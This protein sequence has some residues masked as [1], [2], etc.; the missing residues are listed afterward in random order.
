MTEEQEIITENL[1][2]TDKVE[3]V[4]EEM[5]EE[6]LGL[7]N[8]HRASIG[9]SALL[10]SSEVYPFAEDH[11]SYM[12]SQNQLSH[13][14]FESRATSITARTNAV[15]IGENVSRHYSSAQLALE[16][17]LEST[18]HKTAIEGDYTHTALSVVLDKDG[19]PYFTQI[20]LLLE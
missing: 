12:I 15:R 18:A 2:A 20:F 3:I 17:W 4:A 16:G 13:D 10:P 19:Q 6:L 8:A 1:E 9:A 5:E 11:N 14:N 7:I